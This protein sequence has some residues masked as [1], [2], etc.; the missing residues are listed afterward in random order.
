MALK[1]TNAPF[2]LLITNSFKYEDK[3][4]NLED[5]VEKLQ[6]TR[7]RLRYSVEA[8]ERNAELIDEHVLSWLC[9]AEKTTAEVT[10]FIRGVEEE[11]AKNKC[12]IG[13]CSRY[14]LTKK[15]DKWISILDNLHSQSNFSRISQPAA[16]R[17]L[18]ASI[19]VNQSESLPSR[20]KFLQEIMDALTDPE[21]IRIGIFGMGGVGKTMVAKEVARQA[22]ERKLFECVV[23]VSVS[24]NPDVRRIQGQIAEMLGLNLDEM[25][26]E[27]RASRLHM[28]MSMQTNILI[29]L[30]DIW[31]PIHVEEIGIPC[32]NECK[33]KILLTSRNRRTIL[34]MG[35][36]KIF[37]L[38]VLSELEA[39]NLFEK[40]VGDTVRNPS[41][42]SVAAEVSRRC[43]G[44]PL[45]IVT[46]AKS[47]KYKSLHEW[48]DALLQLSRADEDG[49][50]DRVYSS[51]ELSYNILAGDE[52]KSLFILCGLLGQSSILMEDLLKYSLGLGLLRRVYTVDEARNRLRALIRELKEHS[53][54]E[55]GERNG[56]VKMNLVVQD[57]AVSIA[58]RQRGHIRGGRIRSNEWLDSHHYSSESWTVISLP[59]CEA[60]QLPEWLECPKLAFLLIHSKDHSLRIH[61]SFFKAIP[62]LKVLDLSGMSFSVLPLSLDMLENLHTLCLNRCSL[63]GVSNIT[64]LSNLEILSFAGSDIS[65]LPIE[66]G[67]LERLKLLDLS[68]CYKLK[69]IP[70]YVLAKLS[71]LQE[72]YMAN[73][74]DQWDTSS[75]A[76]LE[77]LDDLPRLKTLEIHVRN[78]KL[79][80]G[81]LFSER[82]ERYRILIGEDWDWDSNGN[83][84][85]EISRMLKVKLNT[86]R[87]HLRWFRMLPNAE[88][89]FLDEVKGART[90]LYDLNID[91]FPVLK[92]LHVQNGTQI[93]YIVDSIEYVS[94]VAF[95]ILQSLSLENLMNLEKICHGQLAAGSFVNLRTLKVKSC[96]KLNNI[97]SYTMMR[98]LSQLRE[99]EVSDCQN[100]EEIVAVNDAK[101][102]ALEFFQLRSITLEGLP[103]LVSFC[104]MGLENSV[105]GSLPLFE[106]MVCSC[107]DL[108]TNQI[109][110]LH[111]C[112]IPNLEDLKVSSIFCKTIWHRRLSTTSSHLT[113]LTIANCQHLKYAFTAQMVK[114][115]LR[116]KKLEIFDCEFMDRIVGIG[117]EAKKEKRGNILLTFPNLELLKI[118]NLPQ[119]SSF[120]T[121]NYLLECPSLK[122]LSVNNCHALKTLV[123]ISDDSNS[124]ERY[125]ADIQSFFNAKVQFPNLEK[126]ALSNID[127]LQTVFS[128]QLGPASFRKLTT[129]ILRGCENLHA[130][131]PSNAVATFQKLEKLC[132]SDC[133]SLEQIFQLQNRVETVA[134]RLTEL[135]LS[136]LHNLKYIWSKDPRGNF[137]FHNLQFVSVSDCEA[138]KFIFPASVAEA[139]PVL[140]ELAIRDCWMHEIVAVA[141]G[142]MELAAPRFIFPRLTFLKL[143]NL[144]NMRS[145]Y[146]G[147]H[148][149][150]MPRLEALEIFGC[151][152]VM[153]FALEDFSSADDVSVI[154]PLLVAI[155]VLPNL[156]RLTLYGKEITMIIKWQLSLEFFFRPKFL[157]LIS[158]PEESHASLIDFLQSL[159]NLETLVLRSTSSLQVL[160]YCELVN[161]KGEASGEKFPPIKHLELESLHDLKKIWQLDTQVNSSFLQTLEVQFCDK[162]IKLA[163][164]SATFQNLTSLQVLQCNSLKTLVTPS[165]AKSM[166]QLVKMRVEKC[167]ELTEIIAA[168]D[169]KDNETTTAEIVFNKLTDLVLVG[170]DNLTS[171]CSAD[172]T[173]TFPY[174]EE[175][176]VANCPKMKYFSRVLST[177]KLERLR[178]KFAYEDQWLSMRDGDLNATIQRMYEADLDSS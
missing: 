93:T 157:E 38:E 70:R 158:L 130:I 22:Q 57:V 176:T 61:D 142:D 6:Y 42:V 91:G 51:L 116:L 92:H 87:I 2:C 119:V 109:Y 78:A 35:A 95:P 1:F 10:E 55:D 59:C 137:S 161:S 125:N 64:Y 45:L 21:I 46:V 122:K 127:Q 174:L 83:D 152:Q 150:E 43:A 52:V 7:D 141:E 151:D 118:K 148:T 103:R 68:H 66:L 26:V 48:Q 8:S 143:Q 74:F 16:P 129:M 49:V 144:P 5:E 134:F 14:E 62:Q 172:C 85:D 65:E 63:F 101:N 139:L 25:S 11:A 160:F 67:S 39:W 111:A 18:P 84:S 114:S 75:N 145:F 31:S 44:L 27:A 97:L 71:Q 76:S 164:P 32:E 128:S 140:E 36:D 90:I 124:A 175:V 4:Q 33:T 173:F 156:K 81:G 80:P 170:L 9:S 60:P 155:K 132:V 24:Q 178:H 147:K 50:Q 34:D 136:G 138:L 77:E 19:A 47:L 115:F 153:A 29:I 41:L 58:S 17:I 79:L 56:S 168:D 88:D 3:V 100:V 108:E 40:M 171:F 107:I 120:C 15:A 20:R 167:G 131:F 13:L 163:P 165:V 162:L 112:R 53:L 105:T 30:D 159:Q 86:R 72:L 113:S 104:S 73:S 23:M 28:R 177:P 82:L 135:H 69:T 110:I 106:T 99:I 133:S 37:S 94:G 166:V 12:F 126:L 149:A 146:P 121:A 89:L 54:L 102:E 123:Y 169:E 117:E 96:N 154:Q 98:G